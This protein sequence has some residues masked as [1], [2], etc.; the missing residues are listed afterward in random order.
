MADELIYWLTNVN[1]IDILLVNEMSHKP[2]YALRD[3]KALIRTGRIKINPDVITDALNDFG[4]RAKDIKRCL[5]KLNDRPHRVNSA[6]NH[7]Y[8]TEQH[9]R[10]TASTMMDYY[11]AKNIME[12]ND[13]YTHLYI[14]PNTGELVI[15][16]FKEL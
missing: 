9:Y 10:F 13:V 4:W 12:G 14:H 7:Y 1:P 3:V 5:L 2:H 11:K 8:K 15:S 6:K 16:S